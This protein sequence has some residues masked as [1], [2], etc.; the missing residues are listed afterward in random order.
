M[1]WLGAAHVP[2]DSRQTP[3][4]HSLSSSH[5]RQ[6]RDAA[7]HVGASPVHCELSMQLTHAPSGAQSGPEVPTQSSFVLQAATQR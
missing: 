2:A 7:S 4:A 3:E 5:L 1:I 6:L